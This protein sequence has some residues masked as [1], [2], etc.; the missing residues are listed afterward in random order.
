MLCPYEDFSNDEGFRNK[1]ARLN[2]GRYIGKDRKPAG[3]RRY[4]GSGD[5]PCGVGWAASEFQSCA[6]PMRGVRHVLGC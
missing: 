2:G 4:D 1:C 5:A 6:D 3:R